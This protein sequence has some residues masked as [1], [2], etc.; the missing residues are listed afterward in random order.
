[1]RKQIASLGTDRRPNT[2]EGVA[3][4][5]EEQNASTDPLAYAGWRVGDH[6]SSPIATGTRRSVPNAGGPRR[7]RVH[8]DRSG[9]FLVV[10]QVGR[11]TG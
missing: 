1:M 7:N 4:T 2:S 5:K 3:A 8:V 10:R 11:D 9:D 6:C